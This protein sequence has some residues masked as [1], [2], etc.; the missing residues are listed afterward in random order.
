[1]GLDSCCFAGVHTA[2]VLWLLALVA[3]PSYELVKIIL[4]A[5]AQA[6]QITFSRTNAT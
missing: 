3:L 2:C 6:R 5:L 4:E 1:M